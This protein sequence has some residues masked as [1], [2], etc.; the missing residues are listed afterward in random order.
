MK[1]VHKV[2]DFEV[3]RAD[4]AERTFWAV[5]SNGQVDRQGD[6]IDPSGWDFKNFMKNPVIPWAHDYNSPPVARAR[7]IKVAGGKLWFKAQF[8]TAEEYAFADTIYRLYQG[9]FLQAFSVGFAPLESELV[10]HRIE[11]RALT[12]TRY[13]KQE[14]Y[15]ISCVTLPANP[16]ALVSLGL[17]GLPQ[18]LTPAQRSA[19]Q[20]PEQT[21]GRKSPLA[22]A[23][24]RR[25]L[26]RLALDGLVQRRLDYHRGLID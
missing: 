8:P 9:G 7:D 21:L 23:A 12:G 3:G 17:A 10:T 11:G 2:L 20:P 16:E 24:A 18:P 13:L 15:E 6:V 26:V 5:A 4:E 22:A 14:L 25:A 19:P 1:L